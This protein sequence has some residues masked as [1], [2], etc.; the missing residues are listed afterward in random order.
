MEG[1]DGSVLTLLAVGACISSMVT[2]YV[3][4]VFF[5]VDLGPHVDHVILMERNIINLLHPYS[6]TYMYT[7]AC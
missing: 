3:A 6:Y 1:G 5:S 4:I 7:G 2:F